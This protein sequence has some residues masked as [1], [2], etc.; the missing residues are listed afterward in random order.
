MSL[1]RNSR[2]VKALFPSSCQS[3][4]MSSAVGAFLDD[5]NGMLTVTEEDLVT[6]AGDITES[7]LLLLLECKL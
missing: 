4:L 3:W 6:L 7:N 5:E 1:L 2:A